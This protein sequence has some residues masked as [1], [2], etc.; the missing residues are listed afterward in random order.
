[1][2]LR[3]QTKQPLV[4]IIRELIQKVVIARTPGRQPPALEVHGRIVSILAAME[5]AQIIEAKFKA[6]VDQDVLARLASVE[7]DTEDKN[8]KLLAG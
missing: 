1:M 7:I 5:T 3:S 4:G 2:G 6:M 8:Q